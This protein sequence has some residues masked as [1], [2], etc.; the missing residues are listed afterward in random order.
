[1][2]T[3]RV[4]MH[5]NDSQSTRPG[6]T[7]VELLVV[8]TIIGMLMALLLPA[9]QSAREAGRRNTCSNNQRN[10]GTAMLNVEATNRGFPGYANVVN[11]KRASWVVPILTNLERADL[12][13]AWKDTAPVALPLSGNNPDTGNPWTTTNSPWAY[14]VLAILECP[15]NPQ[16]GL[17]SNPLSYVVNCG[18]AFT[19]SDNF[20]GGTSAWPEDRNSGVF[21]NQAGADASGANAVPGSFPS[22][23]GPKVTIDFIGSNDGTSNTLMLSESLQSTN[24]ATDPVNPSAATVKNPWASEF[25]IKQNAGFVFFLTRQRNN[26]YDASRTEYSPEASVVNGLGQVITPP[27]ANAEFTAGPPPAGGLAFARPASAHP[28]G[29]NAYFC[30]NHYR[31]ITEEID[32][33]VY[34]QL[35]TPRQ[36]TMAID[37]SGTTP[38]TANPRWDY[39]LGEADY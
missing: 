35:M 27:I 21:F 15:S 12:Y 39:I 36:G 37:L 16:A 26:V 5:S 30:D 11:N 2:V 28:G 23:A 3:P 33:H 24:W 25:Q 14:T 34:T 20:P 6:F 38:T 19:A 32:Y 13:T 18:S 8:I 17:G 10:V 31:F 7:L 9:I 22:S 1:M 29:V 4:T